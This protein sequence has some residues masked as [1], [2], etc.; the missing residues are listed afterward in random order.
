MSD[1]KAIVREHVER[2]EGVTRTWFE[3]SRE[4]N[5]MV[6]TLAVEV[7]FDTDP[8]SPERRRD[9]IDDIEN[10]VRDVLT[11]K[12]IM[13]VTRLKIVPRIN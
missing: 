13:V 4:E 11:N 9:V 2:I 3:W 5:A 7:G 1:V 12:T 10:T 8:N 6:K